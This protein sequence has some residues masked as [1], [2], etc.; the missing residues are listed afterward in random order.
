MSDSVRFPSGWDSRPPTEDG[1]YCD[2][3]VRLANLNPGLPPEMLALDITPM[4]AHYRLSH[5][6]VPIL[7]ATSYRLQFDGEFEAPLSLTLDDLRAERPVTLP[8]TMECA[9]NGRAEMSPR[10]RSMPWMHEAVGTME[11][12][13]ARLA[14]LLARA[15][16]ADG[17]VDFAFEGADR[18]FDHGEL[19]AFGRSLTPNEIAGLDAILAYEANGQPLPPQHGAPLRLIVP[20][21]YGMAS[22]KWLV[23]IAA[24]TSRYQGLQQVQNYRFRQSAEEAG[25]PVTA[26]RVRSLMTPPGVPDWYTRSRWMEPG[27]VR[28]QGRAWS[29][30]APVERVEVAVD[31]N[32][33]PATLEAPVGQYAWRGWYFD[34]RATPGHHA[35]ACRATDAD[36]E[37]Q[38]MSPE[39]NLS[40]FA[41]NAVQRIE[42]V[43]GEEGMVE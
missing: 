17:V 11:W 10:P 7:D 43:V 22:V 40:G 5:F 35:L 4:G 19:H 14:P 12:T 42:V 21:W 2:S 34:W 31:E 18:G 37:R 39:W 38:P 36:G 24:L 15:R 33:S 20:G 28:I 23:R 29:G 6:D 27:P 13:G 26:I 16:P 1:V 9:G 25:G 30:G 41:N 3:D 8:V 32:W